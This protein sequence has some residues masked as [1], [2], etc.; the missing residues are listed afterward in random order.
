MLIPYGKLLGGQTVCS[1]CILLTTM[2]SFMD[3]P[4]IGRQNLKPASISVNTYDM[5][6]LGLHGVAVVLCF[7][8]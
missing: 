6:M 8:D 2:I 7:A 4:A 5:V 3:S 1:F